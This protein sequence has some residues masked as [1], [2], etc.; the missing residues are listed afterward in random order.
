LKIR[1]IGINI[2]RC[3][4]GY[5]GE[6][7]FQK[8][9]HQPSSAVKGTIHHQDCTGT[10]ATNSIYKGEQKM[11]LQSI[12]YSLHNHHNTYSATQ[13]LATPLCLLY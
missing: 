13:T 12:T 3:Q 10:M 2:L 4:K 11:D 7:Y 1:Y 5:H 8:M 6:R 9:H